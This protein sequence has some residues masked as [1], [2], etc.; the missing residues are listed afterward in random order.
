MVRDFRPDPKAY[1]LHAQKVAAQY[2]TE[3]SVY[4]CTGGESLAYECALTN[5]DGATVTVRLTYRL[6]GTV[7]QT[8]LLAHYPDDRKSRSESARLRT[9]ISGDAGL[10][11]IGEHISFWQHALH[12]LCRSGIEW[13]RWEYYLSSSD[14]N[15]WLLASVSM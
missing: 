14:E 10:V 5:Q 13:E 6:D 7:T 2:L 15:G 12:E 9:M 11:S 4:G 8:R 1:N 3:L